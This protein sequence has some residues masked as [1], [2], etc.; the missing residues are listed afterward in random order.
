M[1]HDEITLSFGIYIKKIPNNEN[2][3][4]YTN[5][6]FT[7]EELYTFLAHIIGNS[8]QAPL[9]LLLQWQIHL[10]IIFT[11]SRTIFYKS[12]E[13]ALIRTKEAIIFLRG[14]FSFTEVFLGG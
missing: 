9:A 11:Y 12:Q 1:D 5:K 13:I 7:R 10:K 2:N 6:N 14:I 3:Q 8:L 4:Q